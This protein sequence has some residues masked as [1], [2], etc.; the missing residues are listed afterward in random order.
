MLEE[1][2]QFSKDVV[3]ND[4]EVDKKIDF[5]YIEFLTYFGIHIL[6]FFW[7]SSLKV[8][9]HLLQNEAEFIFCGYF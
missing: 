2:F 1:G 7:N 4:E 8:L 9:Q 6:N 5:Y 3:Q